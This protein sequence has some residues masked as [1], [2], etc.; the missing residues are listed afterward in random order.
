MTC[1]FNGAGARPDERR[2]RHPCDAARDFQCPSLIYYGAQD[3]VAPIH[4]QERL[5]KNLSANGRRLEWHF[6][7]H[8]GH[9]FVLADGDCYDPNLAA[10]VWPLTLD[11]LARELGDSD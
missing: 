3:R 1:G 6:F 2:P 4:I 10:L 9:G 7:P 5:W 11:Y 8:A